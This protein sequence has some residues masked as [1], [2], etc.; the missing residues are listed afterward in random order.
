MREAALSDAESRGQLLKVQLETLKAS[1]VP[2]DEGV[3]LDLTTAPSQIPDA[4]TMA[5]LSNLG[6]TVTTTASVVPPTTTA[7]ISTASSTESSTASTLLTERLASLRAIAITPAN[8]SNANDARRED[9]IPANIEGEGEGDGAGADESAG[10]EGGEGE[11]E[12]EEQV[13]VAGADAAAPALVG[14]AS[15]SAGTGTS[16]VSSK[17]PKK[18]KKGA[19][20]S[21]AKATATTTAKKLTLA[22]APRAQPPL[23]TSKVSNKGKGGAR[24]GSREDATASV[25]LTS[26]AGL[27]EGR[28]GSPPSPLGEP[29][30]ARLAHATSRAKATTATTSAARGGM[31]KETARGAPKTPRG[32]PGRAARG[33]GPSGEPVSVESPLQQQARLLSMQAKAQAR[34]AQAAREQALQARAEA[35][36]AAMAQAHS[37]VKAAEAQAKDQ[38][39]SQARAHAEARER[40]QKLAKDMARARDKA[41]YTAQS[42]AAA[43][44][45][46]HV[47]ELTRDATSVTNW[48]TKSKE[49]LRKLR[50]DNADMVRSMEAFLGPT[51]GASK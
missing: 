45:T 9:A 38:E 20:P 18:E 13:S 22:K 24:D 31:A 47:D 3:S 8:A 26:K 42:S 35:N 30:A 34:T 46:V 37:R 15:T 16:G 2:P 36:K 5:R 43:S 23:S 40:A 7:P 21:Y 6:A 11:D 25:A 50:S 1:M 51:G 10:E 33:G 44:A 29:F 28:P 41:K 19:V 27:L 17:R 12:G 4:T 39:Q 49:R 48:D 32:L 14:N